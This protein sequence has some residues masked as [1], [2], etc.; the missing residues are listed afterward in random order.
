[1]LN[2]RNTCLR[3]GGGWQSEFNRPRNL[4]Y[5][6]LRFVSSSTLTKNGINMAP[7]FYS[8]LSLIIPS[9]AC[10]L[11]RQVPQYNFNPLRTAKEPSPIHHRHGWLTDWVKCS[12][13]LAGWLAGG[14][15]KP[16]SQLRQRVR[17]MDG[18]RTMNTM[19]GRLIVFRNSVIILPLLSVQLLSCP[20]NAHTCAQVPFNCFPSTIQPSQPPSHNMRCSLHNMEWSCALSRSSVR[21]W[22]TTTYSDESHRPCPCP[23]SKQTS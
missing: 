8:S 9:T 18:W 21:C 19:T 23:A 3:V 14:P 13:P 20:Y 6:P 5:T 2:A 16:T 7:P 10:L 22:I 1:M 4:N 12:A 15:R 11:G 17:W